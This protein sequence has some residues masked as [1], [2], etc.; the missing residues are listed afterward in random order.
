[1]GHSQSSR[2]II[3]RL[4]ADGWELK[5]VKGDHHQFRKPGNPNVITVAHPTKAIP[6]G[7]LRKIF[8][9]AGWDWPP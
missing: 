3:D 2:A 5:R 8:R 1:M 7:T 4:E 9:D 6:I